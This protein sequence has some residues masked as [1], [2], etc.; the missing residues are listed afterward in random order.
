MNKQVPE[1]QSILAGQSLQ[2]FFTEKKQN[3]ICASF[4]LFKHSRIWGVGSSVALDV[5]VPACAHVCA[6]C[7][8][9]TSV[10]VLYMIVHD[11]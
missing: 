10:G 2:M 11:C 3:A 4:G 8:T 1:T 5:R 6:A 7:P 9:G